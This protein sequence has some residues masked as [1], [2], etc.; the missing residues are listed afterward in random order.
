VGVLVLLASL[1]MGVR[2]LGVGLEAY[3]SSRA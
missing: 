2:L 1:G 3:I